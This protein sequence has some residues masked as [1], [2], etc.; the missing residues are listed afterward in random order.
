MAAAPGCTPG[1]TVK[2]IEVATVNASRLSCYTTEG[3]GAGDDT[4]GEVVPIYP[5][6]FFS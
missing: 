2:D 3:E 6:S 4:E 1:A 5:P